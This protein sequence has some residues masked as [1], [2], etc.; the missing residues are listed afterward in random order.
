MLGDADLAREGRA[1]VEQRVDLR[2]DRVDLRA[3]LR[4]RRVLGTRRRWG[5]LLP[6]GFLAGQVAGSC[7]TRAARTPL[8]ARTLSRT[9]A[10]TAPSVSMTV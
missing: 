7:I 4:Q 1:F 5:C 9:L 6:G 3:Q 2:V 8:I 10:S